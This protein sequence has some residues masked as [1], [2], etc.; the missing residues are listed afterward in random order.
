MNAVCP[1]GAI[2]AGLFRFP[3][4]E[5]VDSARYDTNKG[6]RKKPLRGASGWSVGDSN[7][8]PLPCEGS[9]LNQLS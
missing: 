5:N 1:D 6:K 4:N 3:I 7:S 9:A 8:R 2:I